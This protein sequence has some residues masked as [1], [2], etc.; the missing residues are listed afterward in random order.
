MYIWSAV[1]NNFT[2]YD[3]DFEPD[4]AATDQDA[5][6]YAKFLNLFADALHAHGKKNSKH[7]YA[8]IYVP[9]RRPSTVFCMN[10]LIRVC[11]IHMLARVQAYPL[12]NAHTQTRDFTYICSSL[13]ALNFKSASRVGIHFGT[14]PRSQPPLWIR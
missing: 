13:Q 6:E 5:Q 10:T 1:Q 12:V 11:T 14:S 2:G 8:H 3:I 9:L 4:D 7:L